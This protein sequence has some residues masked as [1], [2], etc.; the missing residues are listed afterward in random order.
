MRQCHFK[1]LPWLENRRDHSGS[2]GPWTP[3]GGGAD[4]QQKQGKETNSFRR[5]PSARFIAG[6]IHK[7]Q[8]LLAWSLCLVA[9]RVNE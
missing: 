7:K 2:P 6:A 9:Q 4:E 5:K 3:A 8:V 1:A